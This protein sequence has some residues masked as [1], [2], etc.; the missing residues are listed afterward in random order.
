MLI[1]YFTY[2][3]NMFF[4]FSYLINYTHFN[5]CLNSFFRYRYRYNDTN[6]IICKYY[7]FV[8]DKKIICILTSKVC[9]NIII[10][11]LVI[12]RNALF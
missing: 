10:M 7:I 5:C 4:Y 6:N 9:Y 2:I 11:K 3:F 1:R 12:V 8:L